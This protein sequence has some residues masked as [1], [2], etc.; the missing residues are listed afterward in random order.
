MDIFISFH[1][2]GHSDKSANGFESFVYTNAQVASLQLQKIIHD[3]LVTF[4][5]SKGIVDRGKKK[6]SQA[7]QG[8]IYVVRE[9]LM[10]AL[11]LENL[12]ISNAEILNFKNQSFMTSVTQIIG[13]GIA[14]FLK[15]K[16][17]VKQDVMVHKVVWGDT[18]WALATRYK[19]TVG[20]IKALNNMRSDLIIVGQTLKIPGLNTY[21]VQK[22]DT[23]SAIANKFNTTIANLVNLNNIKDPNVISVGQVLRI[24]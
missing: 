3:K 5:K 15:L 16:K 11:L 4:Y 8:G 18:L 24:K 14:E 6:D 21:T 23:L 13:D 22:G 7:S 19:T 12:F 9:T 20:E 10:L 2:N 1:K 17:I